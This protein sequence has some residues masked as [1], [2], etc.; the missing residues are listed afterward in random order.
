M[1]GTY[2]HL[3]VE[4]IVAPRLLKKGVLIES[5]HALPGPSYSGRMTSFKV[6]G[7]LK[8]VSLY[9]V[10]RERTTK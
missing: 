1:L 10:G 8:D 4:G 6:L 3:L 9:R 7:Y 5:P 2:P